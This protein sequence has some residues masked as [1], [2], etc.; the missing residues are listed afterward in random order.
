MN[1]IEKR[2]EYANRKTVG[3]RNYQRARSRALTKLAQQYPD[4]YKEL[5]EQEKLNDEAEG[6]KWLDITGR[7]RLTESGNGSPHWR[8]KVPEQHTNR[9]QQESS[10]VGGEG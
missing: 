8:S 7:T 6:K 10:N 2:K 5:L 3:L 4:E 9:N 1:E